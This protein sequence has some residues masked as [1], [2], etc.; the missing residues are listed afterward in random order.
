MNLGYTPCT[1]VSNANYSKGGWNVRGGR[2]GG[3][4][5]LRDALAHSQNAVAARLIETTG[6]DK[7]IQL[8]SDLGVQ[9][10]I[11]KI[12]QLLLVLQILPFMRC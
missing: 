1:V 7:V 5:A 2:S 10:D 8:A 11:P 9:S 3:M 6:V 4:L 12:I